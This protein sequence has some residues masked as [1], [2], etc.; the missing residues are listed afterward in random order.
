MSTLRSEDTETG[1]ISHLEE[2]RNRLIVIILALVIGSFIGWVVFPQVYY[3]IASPLLTIVKAHQ[4]L[5]YTSHPGEAFF[6][7]CRLAVIIGVM[8]VSPVIIWQLW[9]FI[10]PGLTKREQHAISPLMPAVSLL[11]LIGV[12]M[13]YFMLPTIMTFFIGYVPPGVSPNVAF[14]N[15]INFPVKIMVAFGLAFQLPVV[16]LGLVALR[17]LSPQFLLKQWRGAIVAMAILA[18]IITPTGDPFNMMIVMVP[19]LIL[20]FVT[21]AIAFWFDRPSKRASKFDE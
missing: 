4:G 1:M 2:L 8:L 13:A 10:K 15:S 12:A 7:Q 3:L 17:I 16:L 5:V 6:T 19:L 11:F 9:S 21:V 20:F 18:A 14:E